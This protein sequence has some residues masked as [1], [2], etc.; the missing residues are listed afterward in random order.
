MRRIYKLNISSVRLYQTHCKKN[1]KLKKVGKF[2]RDQL[3][4]P[5]PIKI[6]QFLA[7]N[8]FCRLKVYYTYFLFFFFFFL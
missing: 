4:D 2:P 3:L 5:P 7:F 6:V 8:L 1:T